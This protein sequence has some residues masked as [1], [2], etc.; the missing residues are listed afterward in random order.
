MQNSHFSA[1][2]AVLL[3]LIY[4]VHAAG[5]KYADKSR[6]KLWLFLCVDPIELLVLW[7]EGR[8]EMWQQEHSFWF[9]HVTR[10]SLYFHCALVN[11]SSSSFIFLLPH[12]PPDDWGKIWFKHPSSCSCFAPALHSWCIWFIPGFYSVHLLDSG[13]VNR[14]VL[15]VNSFIVVM[16][17]HQNRH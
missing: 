1:F 8:I 16:V 11:I 4:T 15:C 12:V 2:K 6:C 7:S 10:D 17:S 13:K 3:G 14:L 9:Q 5:S